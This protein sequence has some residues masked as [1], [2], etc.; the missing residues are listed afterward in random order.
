[1]GYLL[2]DYYGECKRKEAG[3][4]KNRKKKSKIFY[5]AEGTEKKR[6][7]IIDLYRIF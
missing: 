7:Q 3:E 4:E 2:Y 5:L 6:R 1:M